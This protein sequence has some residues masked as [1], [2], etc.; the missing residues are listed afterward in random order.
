MNCM[1][2]TVLMSLDCS[3]YISAQIQFCYIIWIKLYK[4]DKIRLAFYRSLRSLLLKVT[5]QIVCYKKMVVLVKTCK[6]QVYCISFNDL[7]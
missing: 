2:I 1:S 3:N 5:R 6:V 7:P 4:L